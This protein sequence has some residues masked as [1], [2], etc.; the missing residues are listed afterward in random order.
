MN[1]G[2]IGL[3]LIGGSFAKAYKAAGHTVFAHDTDKGILDFAILSGAA[4]APLD[5]GAQ[6]LTPAQFA[7]LTEGIRRIRAVVMDLRD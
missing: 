6:S 4:D 5:D 2:I 1:I 3:G 7:D